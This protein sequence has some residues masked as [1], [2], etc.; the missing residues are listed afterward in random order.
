MEKIMERFCEPNLPKSRVKRVFVSQLLPNEMMSELT[1]MGIRAYKLGKTD[2]ISSELAYH[3]DI[4]VNNFRKGFWMCE[5]GAKYIPR[6]FPRSMILESESELGHIYPYDCLF[7]NYRIGKNLICGKGVDYLIKA[8]A[9]YDEYRIVYVQQNYTK[10]CSIPITQNA[11]I[12]CDFYL[13]RALRTNGY[14][15]LTVNDSDDVG[16]SGFSHG[17]I[18]GCAGK[19]SEKL[20]VFTGNLNLYKYGNEIR[21]FC[22]NHGVDAY[23][24]SNNPMYDYGGILPI[25]ELVPKGEEGTETD[26][27]EKNL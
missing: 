27:F 25:T 26:I 24:L 7:N 19:L 13:A 10:C 18:G 9:M 23:S 1:D 11:V 3:P 21:D 12:T 20:L 22:A 4:L 14:D 15:V 17:L 16:L 8:Y 5:S 2:N 6:D